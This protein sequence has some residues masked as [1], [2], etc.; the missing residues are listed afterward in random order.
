[1]SGRKSREARRLRAQQPAPTTGTPNVKLLLGVAVLTAIV[2]V[3]IVVGVSST[4]GGRTTQGSP[5]P[6]APLP[7]AASVNANLRGIPQHGLFL[8]A[9]SAPVTLV[10]YLDLQCPWCGRYARDTFPDVVSAFVR[11]AIVRVEMR[12]LAFVGNDSTRGRSAL[13]AAA[14]R[15]K[16]FQFVALL[17]ANQ[18]TENTGWLSAGMVKAA[19]ASIPGLDTGI[20][21]SAPADAELARIEQQRVRDGVT[22]V[23]T[24]FIRRQGEQSG[25]TMLVNPDKRTLEAALRT[26]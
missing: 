8:G 10:E 25:G 11:R 1:M 16:A 12:P 9:P 17:Y 20:A 13:L 14:A 2:L 7:G 19:A 3:A 5:A 23:P 6:A 4:F 22:G 21:S 15:N 18:G 26:R 24:F